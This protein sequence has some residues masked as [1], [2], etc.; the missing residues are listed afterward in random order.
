MLVK[1]HL[2]S[3]GPSL[4][5]LWCIDSRTHPRPSDVRRLKPAIICLFSFPV[6]DLLAPSVLPAYLAATAV[7]EIKCGGEEPSTWACDASDA[8]WLRGISDRDRSKGGVTKTRPLGRGSERWQHFRLGHLRAA[9]R[10][11]PWWSDERS[12]IVQV[13]CIVV[14][15]WR[16]G[17][18][19]FE[20]ECGR[21]GLFQGP[22]VMI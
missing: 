21:I 20:I 19:I 17:G 11:H 3:H 1:V 22:L 9:R 18:D 15:K 13:R 6:R 7:I 16:D 12:G 4:R 14:E 5:R 10:A 8:R 2:K